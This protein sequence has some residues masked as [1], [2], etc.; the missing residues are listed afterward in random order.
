[1]GERESVLCG[2]VR[3]AYNAIHR[4]HWQDGETESELADR[5]NDAM[6][7]LFGNDWNHSEIKH[8]SHDFSDVQHSCTFCV[9]CGIEYRNPRSTR[10]CAGS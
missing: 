1:M 2:L 5:I 4:D 7:S 3:D 9:N 6:S 10:L 8:P